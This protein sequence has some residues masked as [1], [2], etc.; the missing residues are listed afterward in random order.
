M[1]GSY[2]F[3]P[4]VRSLLSA[5]TVDR[6][7]LVAPG[8]S[9]AKVYKCAASDGRTF[10]LKCW[11][12][13]TRSQRVA[14]VH[15]VQQTAHHGG[16]DFVPQLFSSPL[17]DTTYLAAAGALWEL[18]DW[19]PGTPLTQDA[20][21]AQIARGASA[22]AQFHHSVADLH[23]ELAPPPAIGN[24]LRRLAELDRL[25]PQTFQS[26]TSTRYA[27]P[28][29]E[30]I[31][32]ICS[33]LFASWSTIRDEIRT[34]LQAEIDQPGPI[35][36]VLRD[37]HRQH[38]LFCQDH[39]SGLI[40]FD[41]I[42]IDTP[43]TDLARWGGSFT[44]GRDDENQVWQ[45]VLAGYGENYPFQQYRDPAHAVAVIRELNRSATWISLANWAVW[46]RLECRSFPAGD[47]AVRARINEL[48]T[49]AR[50]DL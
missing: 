10:A 38:L 31:G 8:M 26:E 40:D 44:A 9:G 49:M 3:P 28:L 21:P 7:D 37:V 4:E 48:C 29:R 36:Y 18:S 50:Q 42:R 35:Q 45:A 16:C 39:V 14:E 22:I 24:R 5:H 33:L 15:R 17:T 43:L 2:N 32:E 34:W 46:I 11:P 20:S 12:Q 23:Q 27:E 13:G 30:A 25:L 1:P 47:Q 19:V 6:A 41:A